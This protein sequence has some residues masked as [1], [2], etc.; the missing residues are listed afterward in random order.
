MP[1]KDPGWAVTQLKEFLYDTRPRDL[2]EFDA[3]GRESDVAIAR[4]AHVVE[5]IL[6]RVLPRWRQQQPTVSDDR[7]DPLR[8]MAS[9]ALAQLELGEELAEKLGDGAPVLSASSLHPWVWDGARAMW[10]S[11]FYGQAVVH[12]A[13]KVNAETQNKLGRRDV[14]E[15]EL[16]NQ[17]FSTDPPKI[18][19][20]RL[21]IRPDEGSPTFG[22]VHRGAR[23][24]AEGCYAAMR[25]PLSHET[26]EEEL[27]EAEALE[28]LATF[29]VLAR[30]V[31]AATVHRAGAGAVDVEMA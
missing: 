8:E 15:A 20:P 6:S 25:N 24:L 3:A 1:L 12:A 9:R 5:Q 23:A 4:Q 2:Y 19:K 22:S 17:A 28:Q 27:P 7:W 30:W 26:A 29:S 11:G 13:K 21:R 10:Q 14:G 31:D 18:G 16:F